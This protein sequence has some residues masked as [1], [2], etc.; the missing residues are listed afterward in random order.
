MQVIIAVTNSTSEHRTHPRKLTPNTETYTRT[1]H[2]ASL[3]APP[4]LKNHLLQI[5]CILA[6]NFRR[7]VEE[8]GGN[9]HKLSAGDGYTYLTKQV[10]AMDS[11]ERGTATL[12]DYY[13]MKGEAPGRWIGSG[14]T[15]LDTV[16]V[17]D[18]VTEAQMKAL[19]GLGRHPDADTI[20]A[21]KI[22]E[23]TP[24]HFQRN[25]AR[26]IPVR[27]AAA[28]AAERAAEEALK[29]SRLGTPFKIYSQASEFRQAVAAAYSDYN[30][31]R[32]LKWNTAVPGDVRA[33]IRTNLARAMFTAEYNRPP[34]GS[35]ELASW[36]AR[37]SR[38]TTQACAGYDWTLY[39]KHKSIS[40]L[41]ALADK[42]TSAIVEQAHLDA[43]AYTVDFLEKNA[44]F[45][46]TGANGVAQVEVTGL[47]A[48]LFT[49]RDSRTGDPYLH[50][51]IA[52]SNKVQTLDGRWLA[53]DG[54]ALY[55]FAVWASEV[56]NTRIETLL[57][58]RLGL[59]F[60]EVPHTDPNKRGTRAV[61]G[62]SR[63]LC[64]LWS[65]RDAAV[66]A[67]R[68][69]LVREFQ[70]TY[71]REP[72]PRE[73]YD[74]AQRAATDTR[75]N[76]HEPRSQA[77]QRAAWYIEAVTHLGSEQAVADMIR[78]ALHQQHPDN[79]S[80]RPGELRARINVIA[81]SV[82]ERVSQSRATWHINHI[83][84]EAQRQV[85][86]ADLPAELTDATV[87]E[88]ITAAL[89]PSR[90]L[91]LPL[92]DHFD[93][94]AALRRRD[95]TSVFV[96]AGSQSYTSTP[97]LE[98][99]Q[100]ILDAAGRRD[101]H[102][103]GEVGVGVALLEY[104]ANHPDAPLNAGQVAL[105]RG[106]ATSG[107]RAQVA[108]APAGTGK[109]T[110]MAVFTSAW[111]ADG[112]TVIGLAPTAA[113][114]AVLRDQ[115]GVTCDT[116]DKLLD[117]IRTAHFATAVG[118]KARVSDWIHG[119]DD[120]TVVIIDEAALAST[121]Q[122]DQVIDYV[123]SRGGSV[124]MVCDDK[125]LAAISAGGIVRAIA[126]EHG[127]LTLEHVIRFRDDHGNP[128]HDEAAA[129]LALREG[130]P[131]AIGF[132]LD[133]SRVHVGDP[134][135]NADDAYLAWAAD[136]EAGLDSVMMAPTHLITRELN[137]RARADRLA[138]HGTSGPETTLRDNTSAS[139]GDIIR[140]T[141]NARQITVSDTDWVRNGTRWRVDRVHDDGALSVI[142]LETGLTTVLPAD[143]VTTDVILGYAATIMT[144]QGITAD[145]GHT[146]LTGQETRN[147]LYMALTRG[148]RENHAYL[149][150]ALTGDEHTLVSD[151]A[152]NPATAVDMITRILGRDG[153]Q[154]SATTTAHRL[155]DP[156]Q[157]LAPATDA[158]V[159]AVGATAQS[160]LD[161]RELAHIDTEADKLHP[162]LT[163]QAAWPTLRGHLAAIAITG[164][165]AVSELRLAYHS[166]EI[167][168][169][170]DVAAV[171]DWRLDSTGDHSLG[172]GPL[173]WL[174]GIPAP[175]RDH[176][177]YGP[178]LAARA[179][180]VAALAQQVRTN[181]QRWT[182]ASAPLWARP[183]ATLDSS[184]LSEVAVWRAATAVD[185]SDRRITGPPCFAIRERRYRAG[186]T[187]RV[188]TLLGSPRQAAGRW[189]P[190]ADDI[191][192]RLTEDPYWPVLAEHL[193]TTAR[194]G[195]DVDTFVRTAAAQRPLPD[196]HPAAALW[197]RL[198]A[199][200]AIDQPY[201]PS[202]N[203]L[204]SLPY[205]DRLLGPSRAEQLRADRGWTLL[206]TAVENAE[207]RWLP[208]ELL[209]LALE[210]LPPHLAETDSRSSEFF[211]AFTTRVT[212][213]TKAPIHEDPDHAGLTAL[214]APTDPETLPPDP[215]DA[216]LAGQPRPGTGNSDVNDAHEDY[217]TA[218][219]TDSP[220]LAPTVLHTAPPP[221]P[222][223]IEPL[224][225]WDFPLPPN[226]APIP[227]SELPPPQRVVRLRGD[228]DAARQHARQVWSDH[229]AGRGHH[230]RASSPTLRGLRAAADSQNRAR[231]AASDAHQ[232]HRHT[233]EV[234]RAAEHE[235]S[236]ARQAA[237]TAREGG[238]EIASLSLDLRASL[239]GMEADMARSSATDAHRHL[240]NTR[241]AWR[242]LAT[243]HA[244]TPIALEHL[245][246][247]HATADMLDLGTL[248]GA[249]AEA[250]H[251]EGE[252]LRAQ[253]TAERF[254]DDG[255]PELALDEHPADRS[256]STQ[257]QTPELNSARRPNRA[258]RRHHPR[259]RVDTTEQPRP[260]HRLTTARLTQ[261]IGHLREQ[262]RRL[263]AQ[264]AALSPTAVADR[265]H[266]AHAH[267]R[268][269]AEAITHA[270]TTRATA[271]TLYQQLTQGRAE[272]TALVDQRDS[273]RLR[274]RAGR[275]LETE[276]RATQTAITDLTA[277]H[278]SA[279]SD[280]ALTRE[281]AIALGAPADRWD[282]ILAHANQPD[283][284]A[285]ELAAAIDE[286]S[287]RELRDEQRRHDS[288]QRAIELTTAL[289][290][291]ITEQQR[292]AGLDEDTRAEEERLRAEESTAQVAQ[293][294][295][296]PRPNASRAGRRRNRRSPP[297]H[298]ATTRHR[299]SNL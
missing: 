124:R 42:P 213:L 205:L 111:C 206:V 188:T 3:I 266:A 12:S 24:I 182:T 245:D 290:A 103:I 92:P 223:D 40:A 155:Q 201:D 211:A 123:L 166:R 59:R 131:A 202:P 186:L 25:L 259:R 273:Q 218:P 179:E 270:R 67:R 120:R 138:A 74:L 58:Q 55:K 233:E 114:A 56:Y 228:L 163:D 167:S 232:H 45:T 157:R 255:D 195:I 283:T 95:G 225:D 269:Q 125:Q 28:R 1:G 113:A 231:V 39:P 135:A 10:A 81:D 287:R 177:Q 88:V 91:A 134:A 2:A 292:R 250:D 261:E 27:T 149:P 224:S 77:E 216:P 183:L 100:R 26:G 21:A 29:H 87:Q 49:H 86:A 122:L 285:R 274:G 22:A 140:T 184:L 147:D 144:S 145:T 298:D 37:N 294:Q 257:P 229:L 46:R 158:Y 159:H 286:D 107:A 220:T 243:A 227:Y 295:G 5:S 83:G 260:I 164:A 50:S 252:L 299:R 53:L 190:L 94:P 176:H 105:V 248:T 219:G 44:T 267:L 73:A 226:T 96:M 189:A 276:V 170:R 185:D 106:F 34:L 61:A 82:V 141:R 150:T 121:A 272:L 277:Q 197:W 78:T 289:S 36:I 214:E 280:A 119:I 222:L 118:I 254:P 251:L 146:V 108:L 181:S 293:P 240:E 110:A 265:V 161:P 6:L 54:R 4:S 14:L 162:G 64:E 284:L 196:E 217:L 142:G 268:A 32:G 263:R 23:L 258:A 291:A 35:R 137:L 116:I 275:Q 102:R 17:G 93:E 84:A 65:S 109:T 174:T 18:V 175:L 200:L 151:E 31:A 129:S 239:L 48:T 7:T 281:A 152:M 52:I 165:D 101:G 173:P 19:F 148:A 115:I 235:Y 43:A 237:A 71:G 57:R 112:G 127:A 160:L 70:Q 210:S 236:D 139:A 33:G 62:I 13:S 278:H 63:S 133:H 221:N 60:V 191:E 193:A 194:T 256:E 15:G 168:T 51:H 178:Y 89:D 209:E 98:A 38:Q 75:P 271:D 117:G 130:D 16:A 169:A 126:E 279:E 203:Q 172:R 234:A 241:R 99:E 230:R 41:W 208:D 242:D 192:S 204:A 20:E 79:A 8:V 136:A 282:Q 132:Y 212:T 297:A 247:A 85:C 246:A 9:L 66:Q 11:S 153:S 180:L 97:I 68:A 262:L 264:P 72:S 199:I 143:Y 296:S 253:I 69:D 76:K 207:T 47:L 156:F 80:L 238:E 249:L 104:G 215:T 154:Q 187:N 244:S 198:T 128:R 171:L 288:D 30:V 90:S